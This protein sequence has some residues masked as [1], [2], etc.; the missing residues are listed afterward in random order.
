MSAAANTIVPAV[1]VA[2]VRDGRVLLVKRGRS[3]S[4]GLY[5]FPG[6]RVEPGESHEDAARREL[7]EE[8]GIVAGGLRLVRVIDI[9]ASPDEGSPAFELRVFAA[10]SAEGEP[11]AG[12]DAAEAA[13]FDRAALLV[14]PT[15]DSVT[16]IALELISSSSKA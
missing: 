8:T 13:F 6:G 16:E 3:P 2:A 7:K 5:A 4:L 9:P 14:L 10:L 15:A 1:S 12:D 11:V